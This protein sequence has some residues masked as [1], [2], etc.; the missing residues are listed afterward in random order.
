MQYVLMTT[1]DEAVKITA[2]EFQKLAGKSGVV[3]IPSLDEM[4]NLSFIYRV[5][6]EE[7]YQAIKLAGKSKM[8]EGRLHDGTRVIKKFG[9]W[10]LL[11]NPGTKIDPKYYPEVSKDEVLTNEEWNERNGQKTLR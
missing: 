6:S 9:R 4:I 2:D 11:D 7:K 8:T 3:Y 10:E 1:K 5:V